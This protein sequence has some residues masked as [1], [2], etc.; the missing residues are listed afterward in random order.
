MNQDVAIENFQE[1]IKNLSF[2][3]EYVRLVSFH[4]FEFSGRLC[5]EIEIIFAKEKNRGNQTIIYEC[6]RPILEL[7]KKEVE[8]VTKKINNSLFE[9]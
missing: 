6:P 9:E 5:L 3:Q 8:V 1:I 2:G 7:P 4:Y